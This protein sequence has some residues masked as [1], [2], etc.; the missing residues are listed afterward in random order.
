MKRVAFPFPWT[1]SWC[2]PSRLRTMRSSTP[3][4][5]G[6]ARVR[7]GVVARPTGHA[8]V[9]CV[10][11]ER[12][13]AA[14]AINRVGSG[15]A[16]QNVVT[17]GADDSSHSF[18]LASQQSCVNL[19]CQH[20]RCVTCSRARFFPSCSILCSSHLILAVLARGLRPSSI[21]YSHVSCPL[22]QAIIQRMTWL[23]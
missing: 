4:C 11:I 10:A 12:V 17:W 19:L 18:L 6:I 14:E 20:S 21:V 2:T 7:I 23:V 1:T 3:C 16:R 13:I 15:R 22:F 8:V 9:A 5:E